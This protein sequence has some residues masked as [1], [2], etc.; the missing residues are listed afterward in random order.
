VSGLVEISTHE[1]LEMGGSESQSVSP[2]VARGGLEADWANSERT[3]R[4][5][6]GFIRV[7]N[8]A[9]KLRTEEA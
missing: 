7:T 8:A 4:S 1:A 3:R 2:E 5:A 6:D 9:A